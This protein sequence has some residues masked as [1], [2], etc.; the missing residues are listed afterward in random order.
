MTTTQDKLNHYTMMN[1]SVV[2]GCR[3]RSDRDHHLSFHLLPLKNKTLLKKW[4]HQIEQKNVLMVEYVL[5]I[6]VVT[7]MSTM[8]W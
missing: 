4:L 1:I 8:L 2:P 6:K 5:S 7:Q 3:S